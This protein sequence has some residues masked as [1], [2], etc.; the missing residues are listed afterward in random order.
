MWCLISAE[1]MQAPS[2]MRQPAEPRTLENLK[3]HHT[4]YLENSGG[5]P[6]KAKFHYNVI[7]TVFFNI[8]IEQVSFSCQQFYNKELSL[9]GFKVNERA[10]KS[11]Q[12]K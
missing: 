8:P 9:S 5:N 1:E 7:D 4:S 10:L 2:D 6:K 11:L 12:I 3:E